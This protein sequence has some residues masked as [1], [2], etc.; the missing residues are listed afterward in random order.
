MCVY[1]SRIYRPVRGWLKT[2]R[3][4]MRTLYNLYNAAYYGYLILPVWDAVWEE[5]N[6]YWNVVYYVLYDVILCVPIKCKFE[7]TINQYRLCTCINL[8]FVCSC[9]YNVT[10]VSGKSYLVLLE[11]PRLHGVIALLGTFTFD[12]NLY[13]NITSKY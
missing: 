7:T 9:M 4:Y 12:L 13:N 1:M 3:L 6:A 10:W 11:Q 5:H 2:C 8:V